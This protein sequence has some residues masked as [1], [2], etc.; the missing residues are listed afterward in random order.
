MKQVGCS[1]CHEKRPSHMKVCLCGVDE[2]EF[3]P[4]HVASLLNL[5]E[6]PEAHCLRCGHDLY[7]ENIQAYPHSDGWVVPGLQ[8]KWWLSIE[9]KCGYH[10]SFDKY[11]IPRQ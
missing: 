5:R 8:W 10:T 4:G 2:I 1:L 6:T 9:C 11:G 3:N 7:G